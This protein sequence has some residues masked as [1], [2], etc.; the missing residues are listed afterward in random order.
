MGVFAIFIYLVFMGFAFS[1]TQGFFVKY[2]DEEYI[3]FGKNYSAYLNNEGIIDYGVFSEDLCPE[4][5]CKGEPIGESIDIS[6][7][8]GGYKG[9]LKAY[10]SYKLKVSSLYEVIISGKGGEI[11]KTFLIGVGGYVSNIKVRIKEAESIYIED[12]NLII[13]KGD[14]KI[15]LSK[16]VAYQFIDGKKV[17]REAEFV[18]YDKYTY[19]FNVKTY[20]KNRELFIDPVTSYIILG[21]KGGESALKVL[22]SPYNGDIYIIGY[23]ASPDFPLKEGYVKRGIK[24]TS[25]DIV[26]V[27]FSRD[28]KKVKGISIIG[29]S[30]EEWARAGAIDKDGNVYVCGWTVSRDF[31][32]KGRQFGEYSPASSKAF[33][34]KLSPDL[35]T[36]IRSFRLGGSEY[37]FAYD[38]FIDEEGYVY[39]AGET[40]SVDFPVTKDA[41]DKVFNGGSID[42]FVTKFDSDLENI[43]ASTYVGGKDGDAPLGIYVDD[44]YVYIAGLTWSYDFPVTE[45]AF[46]K[47]FGGNID[48]IAI[49]LTKDLSDLVASTYIGGL[50]ADNT[51]LIAVDKEGNVYIGGKTF[52]WDMPFKRGGY[53]PVISDFR[54][55]DAYIIWLPPDFSRV[56]G[57]TY[58]G[59]YGDDAIGGMVISEKGT[60]IVAGSTTSH[61]FPVFKDERSYR[62]GDNKLEGQ[63][64]IYILEMSPDLRVIINSVILGG[65]KTE[66]LKSFIKD[67]NKLVLA[68]ETYSEDFPAEVKLAGLYDIFVL[69]YDYKRELLGYNP[70][71]VLLTLLFWSVVGLGIYRYFKS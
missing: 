43:I 54:Y 70:L 16:P 51:G 33:V 53:K 1:F 57:F 63:Y 49:K 36:L 21:G 7:L 18:I 29:G 4:Y 2:N 69:E 68:G 15:K 47:T 13:E 71:I 17:Y 64:D 10:E 26:I 22:K 58:I 27:R 37:E 66:M 52:S 38:M 41:Y 32:I 23:T 56:K 8:K 48:G 34:L 67:E 50:L 12:G 65:S 46:D 11:E 44:K 39:I 24:N 55:Q 9:V 61:N 62:K 6:I 42:I 20:D 25:W 28:L 40:S 30:N 35:K 19:G 45:K 14:K 31:P 3:F 5:R 60:L 59:G